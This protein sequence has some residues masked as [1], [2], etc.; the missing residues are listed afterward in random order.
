MMV[1][2]YKIKRANPNISFEWIKAHRNVFQRESIA[3][4]MADLLA[5]K[6]IAGYIRKEKN[7]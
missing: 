5:K 4:N 1:L 2:A 7:R 3:N 6:G